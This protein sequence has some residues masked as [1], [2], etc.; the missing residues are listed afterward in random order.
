M[1]LVQFNAYET[2]GADVVNAYCLEA[3]TKE[4]VY[5]IDSPELG[6]FERPIILMD[7]ALHGLRS[8]SC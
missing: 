5:T 1:F 8:G 4:T 7:K 6:V 2:W 3:K